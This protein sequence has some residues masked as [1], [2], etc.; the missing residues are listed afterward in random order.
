MELIWQIPLWLIG[1]AAFD[2]VVAGR[3]AALAPSVDYRYWPISKLR[4][5]TLAFLIGTIGLDAHFGYRAEWALLVC[6]LAIIIYIAAL[7]ADLQ[8]QRDRGP[9]PHALRYG[10]TDADY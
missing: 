2:W 9:L 5:V 10:E 8:R 6:L 3:L 1:I 7:L 4:L